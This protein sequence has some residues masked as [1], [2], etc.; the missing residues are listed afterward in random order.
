VHLGMPQ[1]AWGFA[2]QITQI[3]KLCDVS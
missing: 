1:W 2:L 3:I